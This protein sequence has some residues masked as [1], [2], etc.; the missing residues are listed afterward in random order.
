MVQRALE[1]MVRELERGKKPQDFRLY[2]AGKMAELQAKV[3]RTE[4]QVQRLEKQILDANTLRQSSSEKHNQVLQELSQQ[5]DDC[6]S[7]NKQRQN[8]EAMLA[9][10]L[11]EIEAQ[12]LIIA[13]VEEQ[14][15]EAQE[16]LDNLQTVSPATREVNLKDDLF[17]VGEM[18]HSRS[19]LDDDRVQEQLSQLLQNALA[20]GN[21]STVEMQQVL[22]SEQQLRADLTS[23]QLKRR[24]AE[25]TIAGRCQ[26]NRGVQTI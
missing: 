21:D 5:K 24:D 16:K 4:K 17:A 14:L 22:A 10:H 19:I 9:E 23:E 15:T 11:E 2:S 8:M 7:I 26:C 12:R 6:I 3:G 18:E 25:S 13:K 1:V 20:K